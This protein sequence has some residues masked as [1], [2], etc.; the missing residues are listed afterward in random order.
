MAANPDTRDLLPATN[1]THFNVISGFEFL[2]EGSLGRR[3][4]GTQADA[5]SFLANDTARQV[6]SG[7]RWLPGSIYEISPRQRALP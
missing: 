3:S 7:M 5:G 2:N 4:N 6:A 1:G